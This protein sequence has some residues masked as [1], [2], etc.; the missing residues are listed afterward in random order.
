MEHVSNRATTLEKVIIN[1]KIKK[2]L[3]TNIANHHTLVRAN[4]CMTGL[5]FSVLLLSKVCC[6]IPFSSCLV[7]M[8]R[9]HVGI[10]TRNGVLHT[11]SPQLVYEEGQLH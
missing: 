8:Q 10:L 6:A 9:K 2:T 5:E 11:P 3:P 7:I 1:L 4:L